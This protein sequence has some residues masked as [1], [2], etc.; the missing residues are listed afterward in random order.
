MSPLARL[1]ALLGD[2]VTSPWAIVVLGASVAAVLGLLFS[3]PTVERVLGSSG[4]TGRKMDRL[5]R[6]AREVRPS[7]DRRF[8]DLV[9]E[10]LF[11]EGTPDDRILVNSPFFTLV[12]V[13][14]GLMALVSGVVMFAVR[15]DH[16][17][18]FI[19]VGIAGYFGP[20]VIARMH[21][22]SRTKRI[23]ADLPRALPL[24]AV[25]VE[26]SDALDSLFDG[27]AADLEGPLATEFAWLARQLRLAS[28]EDAYAL[29]AQLDSRN[30][31]PRL[32]FFSRL[33]E[34]AAREARGSVKR[35]NEVIRDT[36]KAEL[37]AY[38]GKRMEKLGSLPNKVMISYAM[39]FVFAVLL[40]IL[41]PMIVGFI[42]RGA[43]G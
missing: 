20:T 31:H 2:L 10:R 15:E 42:Q 30:P 17:P 13:T 27:L 33:A 37:A 38:Q 26:T 22:S 7:R 36:V 28:A 40:S 25:R 19:A 5:L 18:L 9:T 12:Q 3:V 14:T 39:P 35:R 23:M 16:N 4:A 8:G 34:E 32:T 29:I 1:A 41:G 21:N 11:R 6:E 43:F 24:L